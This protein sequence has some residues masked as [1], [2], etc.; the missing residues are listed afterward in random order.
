VSTKLISEAL[1][2]PRRRYGNP[3][4]DRA[5]HRAVGGFRVFVQCSAPGSRCAPTWPLWETVD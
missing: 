3:R 2:P 5:P 1:T 4:N